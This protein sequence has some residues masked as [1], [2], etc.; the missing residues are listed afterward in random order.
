MTVRVSL[1]V[2]LATLLTACAGSV[3]GNGTSKDSETGTANGTSKD[4][5]TGTANQANPCETSD[6]V[7]LKVSDI[8][9]TNLDA[10]K[11]AMT[12]AGLEALDAAL[13]KGDHFGNLL[14]IGASY[15]HYFDDFGGSPVQECPETTPVRGIDVEG[16]PTLKTA[17]AYTFAMGGQ[18]F[19][20][21]QVGAPFSARDPQIN[22]L[23]AARD[24][25]GYA[26]DAAGT[27]SPI[28]LAP[29]STGTTTF[30]VCGAEPVECDGLP[31]PYY[32]VLL[33][34]PR[35][36]AHLTDTPVSVAFPFQEVALNYETPADAAA[37]Q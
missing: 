11:G 9:Q 16:E 12:D 31:P 27:V 13:V 7:A 37:C 26:I 18:D 17:T 29:A 3:L 5:E 32:D 24:G 15:C 1:I 20:V 22:V 25:H 30:Q 28:T 2:Y 6:I 33:R 23:D 21:L 34:L 4:S 8:H 19:N 14:E 35:G 36:G 10:L